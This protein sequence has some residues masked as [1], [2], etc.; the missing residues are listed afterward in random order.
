LA[1]NYQHPEE[2]GQDAI[3]LFLR[4]HIREKLK[5]I[6]VKTRIKIHDEHIY[7]MSIFR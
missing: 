2:L 3:R 4:N 6:R 5:F 1:G 7:T